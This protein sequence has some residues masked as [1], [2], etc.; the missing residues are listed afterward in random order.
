MQTFFENICKFFLKISI[1]Q[2]KITSINKNQQLCVIKLQIAVL[3]I[4]NYRKGT[5]GAKQEQWNLFC[6]RIFI[7]TKEGWIMLDKAVGTR[8]R[9]LREERGMTRE[10]LANKAEITALMGLR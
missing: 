5:I 2:Q 6:W 3:Y 7:C 4:I 8:I 9:K 1:K 10:E